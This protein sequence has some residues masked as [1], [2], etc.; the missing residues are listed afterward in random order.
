M[1]AQAAFT[2]A[3]T[4]LITKAAFG[5]TLLLF[6]LRFL[7][8]RISTTAARIWVGFCASFA[9][10]WQIV[11]LWQN[12]MPWQIAQ[13]GSA[14][15]EVSA[16]SE[17]QLFGLW[18]TGTFL[19]VGF[20]LE[21]IG[22]WLRLS[23]RQLHASD[24]GAKTSKSRNA[25]SQPNSKSPQSLWR[26]ILLVVAI[27]FVG[28]AALKTV[29]YQPILTI[30]ARQLA[31][32]H[33][34]ATLAMGSIAAFCAIEATLLSSPDNHS[35]KLEDGKFGVRWNWVAWIALGI[36]LSKLTLTT[37]VLLRLGD[38][39]R[40]EP[41]VQALAGCFVICLIIL[42]VVAWMVPYRLKNFQGSSQ[43]TGWSSLAIASWLSLVTYTVVSIIPFSWPW[44]LFW[45]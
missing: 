2:S 45:T 44:K 4:L 11:L 21:A 5:A 12:Q 38:S 23:P 10:I 39:E 17:Q 22:Q 28:F 33:L 13:V 35:K 8:R 1:L 30:K 7:D 9:C 16:S 37:L 43:V 14:A 25:E 41:S 20:T 18:A 3:T 19:V 26:M 15:A 31:T 32:W 36:F 40:I 42:D 29:D 6:L 27:A 24:T 34:I